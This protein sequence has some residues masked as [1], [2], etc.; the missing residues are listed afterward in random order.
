[1][2]PSRK[3][4]YRA[5]RI[6]MNRV[7]N[8]TNVTRQE[9]ED[10]LADHAPDLILTGQHHVRATLI[11]LN[12]CFSSVSGRYLCIFD[13]RT[14]VYTVS[15]EAREFCDEFLLRSD[16]SYRHPIS[17]KQMRDWDRSLRGME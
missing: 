11:N 6:L 17:I 9:L 16:G 3:E 8:Y 13:T 1:M 15:D 12:R 7:L 4:R 5:E 2:R 14:R 10:L